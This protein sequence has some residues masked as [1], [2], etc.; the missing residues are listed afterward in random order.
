MHLLSR[1]ERSEP[2]AC[3]GGSEGRPGRRALLVDDEAASRLLLGQ[4]LSQ[5]G[6]EVLEAADGRSGV[7]LFLAA[8]PDLVLMNVMMP[9]RDGYE[10]ARR[11]RAA[12]GQR[13][14]PI[15]FLTALADD[16]S[17]AKCVECGGDDF[18]MK[19]YRSAVLHAKITSFERLR[20]VHEL[21]RD[22]R[23]ELVFHRE[24]MVQ[25]EDFGRNVL[26]RVIRR[27]RH[28]LEAIDSHL[29]QTSIAHG[30]LLLAAR[31]PTG[32][33]LVLIG[34]HAIAGLAGSVGAIPLSEVFYEM[35]SRGSSIEEIARLMN[36]KLSFAVPESLHWYLALVRVE[37]ERG[38]LTVWNGS[39]TEVLLRCADGSGVVKIPP[40]PYALGSREDFAPPV[41]A[42]DLA[43]GDRVLVFSPSL[44]AA[45]G[46]AG[47][48]SGRTRL[49]KCFAASE[50]GEGFLE[51]LLAEVASASGDP[52]LP[53]RAV[54]AHIECRPRRGVAGVA[55]S[56]ASGPR[57]PLAWELTLAAGADLLR[58][59]DVLPQVFRFLGRVAALRPQRREICGVLSEIYSH[60]LDR[61]LLARATPSVSWPETYAEY[62]AL[63]KEAL[64]RLERG[65]LRVRVRFWPQ[66][67]GGTVGLRVEDAAGGFPYGDRFPLSEDAAAI[68]GQ[69]L[70]VR[71]G[72]CRIADFHAQGNAVEVEYSWT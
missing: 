66:G 30:N 47:E 72:M 37:P 41:Q 56:P 49:A 4:M 1:A 33:Q 45:W 27:G 58:K 22:Q 39:L 52:G 19:P 34:R 63:R 53:E 31:T 13:L 16:A 6:Y 59:T 61:L 43:P 8:S 7:E 35:S 10:A 51:E 29:P 50:K 2:R 9:D 60:V 68:F 46:A 42:F 40:I 5:E 55:A 44:L 67:T 57:G 64:A 28:V 36:A 11:I 14:V 15:I 38:V 48:N 18:L 3:G 65:V 21:V 23:D 71:S 24:R 20:E 70:P 69:R 25:E 32:G 62:L 12:A 54:L 26:D 17:L